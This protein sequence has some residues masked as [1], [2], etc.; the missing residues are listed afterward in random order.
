[1][2]FGVQER[3]GEGAPH[4]KSGVAHEVAKEV[5]SGQA[6]GVFIRLKVFLISLI[7]I[8]FVAW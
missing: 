8:D 2:C 4:I 6:K 5:S 7:K 1:M 3:L